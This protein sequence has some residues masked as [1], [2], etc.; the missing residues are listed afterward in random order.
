MN[1]S[2]VNMRN[3]RTSLIVGVL[4]VELVFGAFLLLQKSH[5]STADSDVA[6]NGSVELASASPQSGDTHVTAGTVVGAAPLSGNAAMGSGQSTSGAVVTA[7]DS[8]VIGVEQ[9]PRPAVRPRE[10]VAVHGYVESKADPTPRTESRGDSLHR[11][12]LNPAAS[13]MTDELVKASAGLDPALP[14]PPVQPSRNDAYHQG[15]NP[16]AA[17]MTDQLVKES[18]K[19]DPG[20]PP[21]NQPN[22]K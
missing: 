17:A 12:G 15:L 1:E 4:F 14:P 19:L 13:A 20:L 22:M 6:T 9:A 3:V 2:L 10:P 21:P 18:A 5:R 8:P 11:H 16:V 7:A